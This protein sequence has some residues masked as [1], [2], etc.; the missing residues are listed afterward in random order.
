MG[1]QRRGGGKGWG[2]GKRR[3]GR[4]WNIL[5][6]RRSLKSHGGTIDIY[7]D[8]IKIIFE[9]LNSM[10]IFIKLSLST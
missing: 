4:G 8:F 6:Q 3:G 5:F 10:M 7:D 9:H 1:H 2:V